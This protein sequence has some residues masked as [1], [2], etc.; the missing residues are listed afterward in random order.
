MSN[1]PKFLLHRSNYPCQNCKKRHVGCHA[2]CEEYRAQKTEDDER[3]KK[4]RTQ[5]ISEIIA[6]DYEIRSRERTIRR[7]RRR[8][9]K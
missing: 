1:V 3:W 9:L 4:A 5:K 8:V 7:Q 2:G 6:E